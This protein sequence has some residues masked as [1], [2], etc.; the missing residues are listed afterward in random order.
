MVE[1]GRNGSKELLD[2][3]PARR[4]HTMQGAGVNNGVNLKNPIGSSDLYLTIRMAGAGC[5]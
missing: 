3:M 5:P 1:Q 4:H 2:M